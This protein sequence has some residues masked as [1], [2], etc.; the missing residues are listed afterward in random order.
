M[1][2]FKLFL[3]KNYDTI[4]IGVLIGL[5]ATNI[6]MLN[7]QQS[8]ISQVVDIGNRLE[9]QGQE[10]DEYRLE[11]IKQSEK[12]DE[13]IIQYLRCISLIRPE[14][15]TVQNVDRCVTTSRLP[16]SVGKFDKPEAA[17]K[18]VTPPPA[19]ATPQSTSKP[20]KQEPTTSAPPEPVK[21]STTTVE[22]TK[23]EQAKPQPTLVE[24]ATKPIT[25]LLRS[26][27]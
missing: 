14:N 6:I 18:S 22:P 25:D 27:L 15:R 4:K 17:D 21:T 5:L 10:A 12:R 23:P 19:T 24:R 8:T 1:R 7:K 3:K 20:I 16:S 26:I 11:A 9:E 2:N 13:T